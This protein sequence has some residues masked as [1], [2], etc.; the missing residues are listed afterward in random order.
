MSIE[1]PPP[2]LPPQMSPDGKWI[3]DGAQWRPIAVHEAAFPN[4]KSVGAGFVPETDARAQTVVMT[5]PPS[6]R[7]AVPPPAFRLASPAP[8]M[9]APLWQRASAGLD[10][11]R[12]APMAIAAVALVVVIVLVSVVATLAL[13][14]RQSP[15]APSVATTST[16]GP[17]T[18]SES[19]EAAYIVKSLTNPMADLPDNLA[20]VRQ[21]CRVGMTSA[22]EDS[23]I[24]VAN[25]VA[26]TL[27]ILD[28]A[29]VPQCIVT[30]ET[31]LRTDLGKIGDGEQLALKGFSDN[32]R[33]EWSTGYSQ[34][35]TYGAGATTSFAAVKTATPRCESVVTGP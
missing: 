6:R 16:G 11:K 9:A 18:R 5:P 24:Q 35:L 23:L 31:T 4:W 17:A 33:T 28:K 34:V 30:P 2:A 19:A 10:L 26:P 29:N 12:Y 27:P 14:A 32:K 8:N 22:C 15:S 25:T 3:W 13:T 21:A 1:A 7:D 20:S